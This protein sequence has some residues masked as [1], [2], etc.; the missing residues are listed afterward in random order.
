MGSV[1]YQNE[2]HLNHLSLPYL[3]IHHIA[4]GIME[5]VAKDIFDSEVTMTI[6]NQSEEDERTGKKE[7]VVFLVKQTNHV[8]HRGVGDSPWSF[9]LRPLPRTLTLRHVKTARW[10]VNGS[11]WKRST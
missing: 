10:C 8:S 3:P 6:V 4:A 9:S 2:C 5:A 7:H 11:Y 1:Q